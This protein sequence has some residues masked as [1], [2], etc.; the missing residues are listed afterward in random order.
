MTLNEE[1]ET[2]LAGT[3]INKTLTP[4]ASEELFTLS[5]VRYVPGDPLFVSAFTVVVRGKRNDKLVAVKVAVK[6][7]CRRSLR[8]EIQAI[9][10]LTKI[11]APVPKLLDQFQTDE[12]VGYI[13]PW[14]KTNLF[15][16]IFENRLTTKLAWSVVLEAART[17]KLAHSIDLRHCDLKPEN[18]FFDAEDNPIIADWNLA[19]S[20]PVDPSRRAGTPAYL[21]RVGAATSYRGDLYRL[22][23]LMYAMFFSG[24]PVF[25]LTNPDV[26]YFYPPSYRNP[27]LA[28]CDVYFDQMKAL[29]SPYLPVSLDD[30]ISAA[31]KAL[32]ITCNKIPIS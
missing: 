11:S 5:G 10:A 32:S 9:K 26:L 24:C 20:G 7:A 4:A 18:V 19:T 15:D 17:Y 6:E 1:L 27:C 3:T 29:S 14:Y 16:V 31:S 12:L 28:S 25:S 21:P 22:G 8:A 23:Y 30:V 13:M 2:L